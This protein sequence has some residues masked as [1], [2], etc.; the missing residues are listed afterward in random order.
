MGLAAFQGVDTSTDAQKSALTGLLGQMGS[1]GAEAYK[2]DQAVGQ[3][4]AAAGR[5][6]T[7]ASN[8]GI[9]N[10]AAASAVGPG[11]LTQMLAARAAEPGQT[12]A[13][14]A[15][16]S[17]GEFNKYAGMLQ[18]GNAN[19]MNAV[20]GAAPIVASQAQSQVSQIMAD[21]AWKREQRQAEIEDR[22]L[23]RQR[24]DEQ[25][26]WS[27]EDRMLELAAGK[28]KTKAA[29]AAPG[30]VAETAKALG[31]NDRKLSK[32]TQSDAY[33]VLMAKAADLYKSY[34]HMDMAQLQGELS[35]LTS[36]TDPLT[37]E[38][39]SL[40]PHPDILALV[41]GQMQSLV[42]GHVTRDSGYDAYGLTRQ[43][44]G[45]GGGGGRT[46]GRGG[47][48]PAQQRRRNA[49]SRNTPRAQADETYF[50]ANFSGAPLK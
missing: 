29:E 15:S 6:A 39:R 41:M 25:H 14:L 50:R 46:G 40:T 42:G 8:P 28:A 26:Q 11:A 2:A 7:V 47:L 27:V 37:G 3:H 9:G 12:S 43:V 34:P 17:A 19:Y 44:A 49:A 45:G 24:E 16:A 35:S 48:T 38:V 13:G 30:G 20:K 23:A 1:A 36:F 10:P 5:Q 31:W 18:S 22:A 33:K 32:A 21:L 4:M